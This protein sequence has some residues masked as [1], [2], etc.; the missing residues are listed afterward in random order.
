[1]SKNILITGANGQLGSEFKSIKENY[2]DFNFIFVSKEALNITNE[3]EVTTFLNA[4]TINYLVNCAAYTAVDSAEENEASAQFVNATGAEILATA[5]ARTNTVLLH[6]S[7][8]YVFDGKSSKAYTEEDKT[9][10][11][12]VYGR[13]KLA[14]EIA[15]KANCEAHYIVRTSWL[16]S[17]FNANFVKSMLKLAETRNKL[18]I[19]ADQYGSPTYAKDLANALMVMIK[20]TEDKSVINKFGVYHYSN[21]Q[22]TTWYAFA[23]EIMEIAKTGCVINPITTEEYPLPAPRPKDSTMSKDKIKNTF[24]LFIPNWEDSLKV[25]MNKLLTNT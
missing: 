24:K 3:S 19:V 2:A 16:Y 21:E 7:T 13:S 1:M 6:V 10:P 15:I 18:G 4:N 12:S 5:C 17:S 9:A 20:K 11:L 23:K 25:C 14:G 22:Q 8:D